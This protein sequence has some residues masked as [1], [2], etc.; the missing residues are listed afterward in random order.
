M[1]KIC[2]RA[3]TRSEKSPATPMLNLFGSVHQL[4]DSVFVVCYI[5]FLV[6]WFNITEISS[7]N[8]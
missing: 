6:T 4:E 7:K 8:E 3:K 5:T 1:L 2:F